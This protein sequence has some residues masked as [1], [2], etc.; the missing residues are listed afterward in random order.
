MRFLTGSG[1]N[2]TLRRDLYGQLSSLGGTVHN[3]ETGFETVAFGHLVGHHR[4]KLGRPIDFELAL[5]Q[6]HAVTGRHRHGQHSPAGQIVR[7]F[8]LDGGPARGIGNN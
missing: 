6:P 1:F 3:A 7:C 4:S 8:K 2:H 5:S